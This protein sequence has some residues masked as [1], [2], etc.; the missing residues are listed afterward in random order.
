M[1]TINV[2]L[3]QSSYAYRVCIGSDIVQSCLNELLNGY[4]EKTV[5]IVSNETINNLYPDFIESRLPEKVETARLNLPD[6]EEYKNLEIFSTI[7]DFLAEN[8]ANRKSILIAFGGGVV[9]DMAGFAAATYMRGMPFIQ[10]PTTLLSQVDSGIGGKTGI[11]HPNGKN[12]IGAFKQPLCTIIDVDFIGTLPP[13]QVVAGYAELIKHGFIRDKELFDLLNR[14][15]FEELI[16][17]KEMLAEAVFKSCEV[18]ARVVEED[19]KETN[20]RAILNFGHTLGHFLETYTN[21]KQMLHGESVII[22]MDF[23]AWWSYEKG[24]LDKKEFQAIHDHLKSLK[25]EHSIKPVSHE[26]FVNII[27]R[28]KKSESQG[29]RFVG[30][31]SIGQASIFDNTKTD[32]L[33]NTFQTF[34]ETDTFLK[35]D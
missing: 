10:V 5:Y 34:L 14:Q 30:L 21:Y 35:I 11:N 33:W 29:I 13:R 2:I 7:L 28:D 24:Y 17:N 23:A 4:S 3:P 25:I 31:N 1:K 12:L 18:K 8:R 20:L 15:T 19:E 27:E 9:G 22:G 32:E 26:K 6:G 16:S